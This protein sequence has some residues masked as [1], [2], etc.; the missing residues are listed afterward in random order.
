MAEGNGVSVGDGVP[1][2]EAVGT[3]VAV[4]GIGVGGETVAVG[5][6]GADG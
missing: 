4:A 1:V 5:L 2:G 3:G 6:T